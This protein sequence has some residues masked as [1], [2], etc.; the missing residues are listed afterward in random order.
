MSID[1]I[2]SAANGLRIA[3]LLESKLSARRVDS[4]FNPSPAD[5]LIGKSQGW[6][7]S[8]AASF[9]FEDR[10]Q[11]F[12]QRIKLENE[13]LLS[14]DEEETA[15]NGLDDSAAALQSGISLRQG[16]L[17]QPG[18]ATLGDFGLEPD[19]ILNLLA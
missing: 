7:T 6:R 10:L 15:S 14:S 5:A 16:F 17:A 3:A 4:G 8:L 18:M 13:R 1:G 9:N 2:L 19:G 12:I 11:E